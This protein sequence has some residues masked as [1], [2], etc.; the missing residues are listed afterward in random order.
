M[1]RRNDQARMS[2]WKQQTRLLHIG[3]EPGTYLNAVVPPL[4]QTSLFVYDSYEDLDEAFGNREHHFI[5][6]REQN[7]TVELTASKIADLEGAEAGKLFGSGMA[8]I[9]STI[10]SQVGSGDHIVCVKSAYGPAMSFLRGWLPR[11]GVTTTFVDGKDA[12]E[13]EAAIRP[14]T[15]LIYL[16]SP[17][18]IIFELQ[19]LR[20]VSAIAKEHGI[21]T[22][23]DNSWA[24]PVFQRPIEFGIDL[25]IHSASKYLGGHSD[26]VAGVVVGRKAL[27]DKIA[28][29]ERVLL[30]GILGP[31][32][33][34]LLLRGLRTLDVRLRRH[35][36]NAMKVAQFLAA[37]PKVAR[38]NYPGLP[39]YP[40]RE[41]AVSQMSGSSGLMS[42]VIDTDSEGVRRF[43]NGL[44][45]FGLGVS[46]GGFESL[47][48]APIISMAKEQPEAVWKAAGV[49]PA[50]VR[51]AI[52]LEDADDLISDLDTALALV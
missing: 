6:T 41:L 38:V 5:Y 27:V 46:W 44:T 17:T 36:Q 24:T 21:V 14:E 42:I 47:A 35:E 32:E 22:A 39:S 10:L 4:F 7:P 18:S 9:S 3:E 23:I 52:G 48:W 45:L 26:I 49:E 11:F 29:N 40:Q 31:F 33:A 1:A 50:L 37:H 15:K 12:A 16:E 34:W 20:A 19:D 51:L 25:V 8:A 43:V 13:F 30:G 2:Q 28:A